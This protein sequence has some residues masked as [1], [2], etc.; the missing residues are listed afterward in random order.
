M[1]LK[2]N[3]M[4]SSHNPRWK[5]PKFR[6]L[7]G[8]M[9]DVEIA[10]RVG[11]TKERIRQLRVRY[12]VPKYKI[13]KREGYRPGSMRYKVNRDKL[14]GHVVDREIAQKYGCSETIVCW[15]RNEK[16]IPS[17]ISQGKVTRFD[18]S[19]YDSLL[20]TMSD[21]KLSQIVGCNPVT[22][23]RRRR[24]LKISAFGTTRRKMREKP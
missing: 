22:V 17:M 15:I 7:L 11:L 21:Q 23:A 13:Q 10:R 5:E 19:R 4:V 2:A 14:L 24:R 9:T 20:G 16:G 3:L 1:T 12:Q 18:W 6:S 8:K